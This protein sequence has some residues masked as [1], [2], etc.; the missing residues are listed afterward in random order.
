MGRA[1]PNILITFTAEAFAGLTNEPGY[2]AWGD[3]IPAHVVRELAKN[4]TL[5]RV[6]MAGNKV[7]DLGRKVRF[8]S[9]DQYA[10]M[11]ARDGHCRWGECDIPGVW[12]DADHMTE[13]EH[14]G[15]TD[16]NRLWLLCDHHHTERHQPGVTVHGDANDTDAWIELADGTRI[17]CP[18]HGA[19]NRPPEPSRRQ[20]TRPPDTAP[21]NTGPPDDGPPEQTRLDVA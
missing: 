12:C 16:I 6:V 1:N 5:Q 21:P 20:Q 11:V 2:T 4:A 19:G 8:A 7:L 3:R 18:P 17:D 15:T 10:A 13:W 14:G 9:E